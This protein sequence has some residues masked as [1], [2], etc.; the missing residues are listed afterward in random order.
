MKARSNFLC[1]HGVMVN[2]FEPIRARVVPCLFH[3]FVFNTSF[4]K[5][6]LTAL[7]AENKELEKTACCSLKNA[8]I[9]IL[10]PRKKEKTMTAFLQSAVTDD[11]N[12]H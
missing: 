3:K 1:F 10:I 2:G 5:Y 6:I 8:D 7:L 4:Q 12:E 11:I 9:F